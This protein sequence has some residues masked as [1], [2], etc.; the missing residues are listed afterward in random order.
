MSVINCQLREA[1]FVLDGLLH[2]DA[3]RIE[4]HYVDTHGYT[5]LLFGVCEVLGFR[6][7]P[8]LRDLP[9]QVIYR[10]KKGVDYAALNHVL[11]RTVR[12]G[13]I[14]EHWDEINRVAASLEDGLV[15]PSLIMVK[16]QS[17]RRQHPLQQAMQELGRLPK[18]RHILSYVE[19]PAFRRR[20]LVGLNK[21]E[22]VHSM[23][24]AICF[25]RQGRFPD[26]DYQ[27]Q[28]GRASALSLLLNAIIV[29]NTRYLAAA[30]ET[31]ARDGQAVPE[32]AW[33]HLSPLIWEHVLVVGRY[34]FDEP[35][36]QGDLRPLRSRYEQPAKA[37]E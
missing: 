29:W 28:L 26:R 24:R 13:L 9:D 18:T 32:E 37:L 8:R 6:F 21:Q 14:V 20:V 1:P 19:D 30:A 25:G 36:I 17:L 31:L 15:A 4:E 3:Y 34:C 33:R 2:Q 12:E 27:A 5:E 10:A 35:V 7:A 16:L 23:A 22:R 11:R